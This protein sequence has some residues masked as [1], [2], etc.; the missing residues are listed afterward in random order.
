MQKKQQELIYKQVE[1]INNKH[2]SLTLEWE[3]ESKIIIN[4][5]NEH[6][7]YKPNLV[8]LILGRVDDPMLKVFKTSQK[9]GLS[10]L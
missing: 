8:T 4:R 2:D 9:F 5:Q 3:E 6:R 7:R 1:G 10:M